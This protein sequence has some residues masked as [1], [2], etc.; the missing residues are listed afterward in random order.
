MN[1]YVDVASSLLA[2]PGVD[3][4]AVSNS[5]KTALMHAA[6]HDR[7]DVARLL[8]ATPGIDMNARDDNDGYTAL[9]H[10]V[11][12][13]GDG[14]DVARLLLATPGVDVNA[15][16]NEGK[17]ALALAAMYVKG[18]LV[19]MLLRRKD[20]DKNAVDAALEIVL[21]QEFTRESLQRQRDEIVELLLFNLGRN[22]Q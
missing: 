16:D 22:Q 6:I 17:T 1:G 14:V 12:A 3:A 5:G 19:E 13:F 15:K 4:N 10:A 7:V 20:V 18:E 8:L 9:M 21:K 2:T 11:A